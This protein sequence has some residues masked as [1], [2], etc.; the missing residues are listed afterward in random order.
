MRFAA[1]FGAA[2]ALALSVAPASA[3]FDTLFGPDVPYGYSAPVHYRP[4][5]RHHHQ[6]H[7]PAYYS[8]APGVMHTP[9]GPFF[10]DDTLDEW[11]HWSD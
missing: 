11:N 1:L 5:Y 4:Y 6:Y 3:F 2:A 8:P 7:R 10:W 9:A